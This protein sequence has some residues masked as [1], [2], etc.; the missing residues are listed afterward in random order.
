M[1]LKINDLSDGEKIAVDVLLSLSNEEEWEICQNEYNKQASNAQNEIDYDLQDTE[2]PKRLRPTVIMFTYKIA[3]ENPRTPASSVP[4]LN[5][6]TDTPVRLRSKKSQ[7][8]HM[9]KAKRCLI[10]LFEELN[11]PQDDLMILKELV[12]RSEDRHK[13]YSQNTRLSANQ[14][15][16][17][18]PAA[19]MGLE[20]RFNMA[21]KTPRIE[22]NSLKGNKENFK[23][24]II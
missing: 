12:T 13:F 3:L 11:E 21:R 10:P 16:R 5:A 17:K 14:R 7:F 1:C 23:Q 15:K 18:S 8:Q 22:I 19:R 4:K 20:E 24:I 2:D 6:S 9:T